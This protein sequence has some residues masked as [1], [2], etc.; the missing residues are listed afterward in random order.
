MP[1][2]RAATPCGFSNKSATLSR[3]LRK[4]SLVVVLIVEEER[5]IVLKALPVVTPEKHDAGVSCCES[6]TDIAERRTAVVG[7]GRF[8]CRHDVAWNSSVLMLL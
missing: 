7:L 5:S 8:R 4:L 3:L 6:T 1:G 2:N